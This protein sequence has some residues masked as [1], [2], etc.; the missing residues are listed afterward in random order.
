M[1]QEVLCVREGLWTGLCVERE[2]YLCLGLHLGPSVFESVYVR[3]VLCAC[4]RVCEC[5][6][7]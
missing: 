4:S 5:E 7:E 3:R 2:L 1:S 6:S